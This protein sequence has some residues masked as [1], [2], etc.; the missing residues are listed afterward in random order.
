MLDRENDK[1]ASIR[2]NG[3]LVWFKKGKIHRDGDK[4]AIIDPDGAFYWYTH[5]LLNRANN[6]PACIDTRYIRSDDG[7]SRSWYSDGKYV[8]KNVK[9]I[10]T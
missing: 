2:A 6:M 3:N 5:G 7:I 4:P 10:I 1:P 8:H 9:I